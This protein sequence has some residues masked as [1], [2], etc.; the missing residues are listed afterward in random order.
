MNAKNLPTGLI[1]PRNTDDE[2]LIGYY[3]GKI[4]LRKLSKKLRQETELIDLCSRLIQKWVS[5]IKVV[6]ILERLA[7]VNKARAYRVYDKTQRLFGEAD[8]KNQKFWIDI[9]LGEIQK[10]IDIARRKGD[11]KAVASLRKIKYE[12]IKEMGS[13][14]ALLY[15]NIQPPPFVLGF[16]PKS[17]EVDLPSDPEL[18]VLISEKLQEIAED[19]E[20]IE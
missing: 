6:P 3:K 5:R 15:E 17:K 4:P 10:D 19:A 13:S 12:Y 8:V 14:D 16:F 20:T 18:S 11:H 7:K 9:E 2:K 1:S